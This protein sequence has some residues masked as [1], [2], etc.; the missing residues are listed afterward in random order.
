MHANEVAKKEVRGGWR[1]KVEMK[2]VYTFKKAWDMMCDGK[3]GFVLRMGKHKII[4]TTKS[5]AKQISSEKRAVWTQYVVR[6]E[7]SKSGYKYGAKAGTKQDIEASN[8]K[9]SEVLNAIRQYGGWGTSQQNSK[10]ALNKD[11]SVYAAMLALVE[12]YTM[13]GGDSGN[14]ERTVGKGLVSELVLALA[15]NDNPNLNLSDV[16][17]D[18]KEYYPQLDS[19]SAVDENQHENTKKRAISAIILAK[20]SKLLSAV[21]EVKDELV[22]RNNTT[23]MWMSPKDPTSDKFEVSRGEKVLKCVKDQYEKEL[24]ENNQNQQG[25]QP[26]DVIRNIKIGS[27][28][29][30]AIKVWKAVESKWVEEVLI[31]VKIAREKT[32]ETIKKIRSSEQARDEIREPSRNNPLSMTKTRIVSDEVQYLQDRLTALD[33]LTSGTTGLQNGLNASYRAGVDVEELGLGALDHRP[34]EMQLNTIWKQNGNKV[35]ENDLKFAVEAG[36]GSGKAL[37]LIV[38][39]ELEI[40]AE[41][42]EK[43]WENVAAQ[44]V[45]ALEQVKRDKEV[46]LKAEA[47]KKHPL[48]KLVDNVRMEVE[49]EPEDVNPDRRDDDSDSDM[50]IKIKF[51]VVDQKQGEE[52]GGR[53][54]SEKERRDIHDQGGHKHSRSYPDSEKYEK[55]PRDTNPTKRD[56]D[57]KYKYKASRT[58]RSSSEDKRNKSPESPRRD[59]DD[60]RQKG[61]KDRVRDRSIEKTKPNHRDQSHDSNARGYVRSNYK[62]SKYRESR[63]GERKYSSSKGSN[64]RSRDRDRSKTKTNSREQRYGYRE[65]SLGSSYDKKG[66]KSESYRRRDG[67]DD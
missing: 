8:T 62:P 11:P 20:G 53:R 6:A 40:N 47:E 59:R 52:P 43:K 63:S 56:Q 18:K 44:A 7:G 22:N 46:A 29:H 12:P 60:D 42:E 24:T 2:E 48:M 55:Q 21:K 4:F 14:D 27:D 5:H 57:G 26:L 34:S 36:S 10:I 61:G 30:K 65:G 9:V 16:I 13:D 58:R 35:Y 19:V 51:R 33:Y 49:E 64:D 32:S 50:S 25:Y 66:K 41:E 54:G 15:Q 31:G 38:K 1:N 23:G 37:G 3:A 67:G 39:K 45:S 28:V 17:K